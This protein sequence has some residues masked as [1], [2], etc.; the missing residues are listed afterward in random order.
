MTT[1]RCSALIRV[2]GLTCPTGLSK[3]R[4]H[5][6]VMTRA[7]ESNLQVTSL[8]QLLLSSGAE[9]RSGSLLM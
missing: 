7:A 2:I 3:R 5:G 6:R 9:I 4:A 8:G 1:S